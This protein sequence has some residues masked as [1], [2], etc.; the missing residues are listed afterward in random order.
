MISAY[1]LTTVKQ[2]GKIHETMEQIKSIDN[3]KS[4]SVVSGKHDL[5]IYVNTTSLD[6]LYDLTN[7]IQCHPSVIRTSTQ[8]IEQ[9][10]RG[11]LN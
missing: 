10:I 7:K 4:I 11:S 2:N 9:E 8:I 1:V 6:K 5:I 3:L